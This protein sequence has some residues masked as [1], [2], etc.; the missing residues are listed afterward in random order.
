MFQLDGL[1]SLDCV[2][3]AVLHEE[4]DGVV[5]VQLDVERDGESL[6]GQA[7][8]HPLVHREVGIVEEDAL[9]GEDRGRAPVE[10]RGHAGGVV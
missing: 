6:P 2:S 4:V 1:Q 3:G 8:H 9:G 10:H 7:G 5:V